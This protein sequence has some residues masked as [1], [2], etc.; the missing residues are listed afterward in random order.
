MVVAGGVVVLGTVAAGV[1]GEAGVSVG[2]GPGE[3][4]GETAAQNKRSIRMEKASYK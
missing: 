2:E 4:E 3:A 1:A